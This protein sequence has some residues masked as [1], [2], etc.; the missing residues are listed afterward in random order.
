MNNKRE[1]AR[2]PLVK[3]MTVSTPSEKP[4]HADAVSV[5]PKDKAKQTESASTLKG[6]CAVRLAVCVCVCVFFPPTYTDAA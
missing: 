4:W 6:D 1:R 2:D 3:K 5:D